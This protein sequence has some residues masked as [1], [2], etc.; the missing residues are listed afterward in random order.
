M[1]RIKTRFRGIYKV[2]NK[3]YITYRISGKK[4]EKMIEGKLTDALKEKMERTARGKRGKYQV[5]ERQEKTTFR[6]LFKIYE[7]EGEKKAY[8][9]QLKKTY[10]DFFGDLRL[11][12]I[13][14]GDLF[15]F[16]EKIKT[17]PKLRGRG[18][19]KDSH[20]NRI[21]A[22]LRRLFN[23]A[24]HRELLEESMN[25]FPKTPKSGLFYP[26]KRG[27][28][29]FF[30][31]NQILAIYKEAPEWMKTLIAISYYTGMRMGEVRK[32]RWEYINM[33]AGI[34]QLP[35]SK[36]LKDPSG[37]G[38]RIVMQKELIDLLKNL[39]HRSDDWVFLRPDGLPYQHW[40]IHKRFKAL[41]KT[42]GIDADK[43]SWKDIRHTTGTLLHLKGADPL[44]IKDQLRHTSIQT[45]EDFY[46]GSDIEYQR[47]QIQRLSLKKEVTA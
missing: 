12:Q 29:N 8:I 26:E 41:L 34:V 37:V 11:S 32:L 27:R 35:E 4:Y 47:S 36:T 7:T 13:T 33:E 18:E 46:I 14:R 15:K 30:T 22:G 21:L 16:K 28:R 9:L 6:E 3:Y 5:I 24:V 17:T 39:P 45:T 23:F 25:P 42:L 2:G 38:Q 40:D 10:E 44:A 31:E 20:V 1:R 19:I 43:F